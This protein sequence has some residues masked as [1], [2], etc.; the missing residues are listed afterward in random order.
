MNE[1]FEAGFLKAAQENNIEK[2]QNFLNLRVNIECK[3]TY[4]RTALRLAII[5]GGVD[6]VKLLIEHGCDV[7]ESMYG[8]TALEMARKYVQGAPINT[9]HWE[10]ERLI[11]SAI[12]STVKYEEK[13][14]IKK[15]TIKDM[16]A[17]I[18]TSLA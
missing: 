17:E 15:I 2:M 18:K 12:S 1:F 5:S 13:V 7:Q 8:E 3:N 16:L 9:N 11:E 14:S 10:V 6:A 4:G